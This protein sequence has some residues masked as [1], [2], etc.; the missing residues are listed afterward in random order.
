MR[1]FEVDVRRLLP[2]HDPRSVR[3]VQFMAAANDAITAGILYLNVDEGGG[4]AAEQCLAAAKRTYFVRLACGH[5][6]EGLSVFRRAVN[7]DAL[8][9]F[10]PDL[11]QEGREAYDTLLREADPA[12]PANF[13]HRVLHPMR[14][15]A[16]FHYQYEDFRR[17]MADERE[18]FTRSFLVL[19]RVQGRS[20]FI[21]ADDVAVRLVAEVIGDPESDQAR[22]IAATIARLQG[23]LSTF[24]HHLLIVLLNRHPDAVRETGE[25]RY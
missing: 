19:G 16:V 21:V 3:L 23:A 25:W 2:V 8:T 1:L 12:D 14:H 10:L 22:Q 6:Y 20:R 24:V 9:D 13:F 17:V 4:S 7:A 15:R 11:Q 5:L 18:P